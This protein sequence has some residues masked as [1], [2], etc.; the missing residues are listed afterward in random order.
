VSVRNTSR[1]RDRCSRRERVRPI[2][3]ADEDLAVEHDDLLILSRVIM[4]RQADTGDSSDSQT[5]RRPWLCA[6]ST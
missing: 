1:K 5:P 3:D 6:A 2:A 4:E